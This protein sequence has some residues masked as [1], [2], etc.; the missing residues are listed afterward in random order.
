M[1]LWL[2]QHVNCTLPHNFTM[3]IILFN[4][5]LDMSHLYFVCVFQHNTCFCERTTSNSFRHASM[6]K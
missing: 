2:L 5:L 1:L 4:Q 3:S 6:G